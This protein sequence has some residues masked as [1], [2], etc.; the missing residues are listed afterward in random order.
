[1]TGK[2][3]DG[4]SFAA[5]E[6]ALTLDPTFSIDRVVYSIEEFLELVKVLPPG[7]FVV[8]DE[9]AEWF[10]SRNFMKEENKDLSAILQIFRIS[11]LGVIYTLPAMYQV[12]KNLR[13]MS[14]VYIKALRV[15]R[16]KDLGET[17][18]FDVEMD[19]VTGKKPYTKFPVIR[20]PDGYKKKVTR[21]Y[22]DRMPKDMEKQYRNKKT[23]F[24]KRVIEEKL[25]KSRGK[26]GKEGGTGTPARCNKCGH[27]WPTKSKAKYPACPS[28]GGRS[29]TTNL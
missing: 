13:V 18:Y 25:S 27:E 19:P 1:M 8:A 15:H 28:C 11:R 10:S 6:L 16:D 29:T 3:G 22:F 20:G 26:N 9:I 14:D 12:D 21:V 4:K 7:S 24:N 5:C 17:K 23:E 2:R